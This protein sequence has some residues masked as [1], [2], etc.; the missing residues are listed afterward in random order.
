VAGTGSPRSE[1]FI[2]QVKRFRDEW[3]EWIFSED[4]K[5]KDSFHIRTNERRRNHYSEKEPDFGHL[6]RL[7]E[8]FPDLRDSL[9]SGLLDLLLLIFLNVALFMASYLAFLRYDVR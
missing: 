2:A 3:R 8:R 7:S 1:S 4:R 5:D 6:P 9:Q